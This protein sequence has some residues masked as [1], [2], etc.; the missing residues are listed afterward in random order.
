MEHT[1]N[2][3]A[4]LKV[5]RENIRTLH[6]HLQG[7]DW[8]SDHELLGEYYEKI[9]EFEDSVVETFLGLDY[10]DVPMDEACQL[11]KLDPIRTYLGLEAFAR[12]RR[13]FERLII[14]FNLVKEH[15]ELPT[16]IVS[17]FEEYEYWLFLES[18]YKLKQRLNTSDLGY[19]FKDD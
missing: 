4:Y 11:F 3:I 6:R 16:H 8:L 19:L 17:K 10:C 13:Y 7:G 5:T 18:N 1:K 12:V 14:F 9:D 15:C 2:L